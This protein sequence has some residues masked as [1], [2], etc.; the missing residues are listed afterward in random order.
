MLNQ[1]K[2]KSLFLLKK[3][4]AI[5]IIYENL[6]LLPQSQKRNTRIQV[7]IQVSIENHMCSSI[8]NLIRKNVSISAKEI[9]LLCHRKYEQS[10]KPFFMSFFF[11]WRKIETCKKMCANISF[12]CRLEWVVQG[13][14][15]VYSPCCSTLQ[16]DKHKQR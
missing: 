8:Q 4:L 16:S 15:F 11:W 6:G 3:K 14:A 7:Y 10:K 5:H 9:Q 12:N 2:Y 1:S 13:A